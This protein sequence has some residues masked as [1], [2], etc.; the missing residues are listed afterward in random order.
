MTKQIKK[1]EK[2]DLELEKI[3]EAEEFEKAKIVDSQVVN[4]PH[5]NRHFPTANHIGKWKNNFNN[6]F[7]Q[8]PGRAAWRGR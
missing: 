6:N 1:D 4:K 3:I 8:R 2:S 5:N 7:K